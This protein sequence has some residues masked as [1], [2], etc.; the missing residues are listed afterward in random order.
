MTLT[1][2]TRDD[3][4]VQDVFAVREHLVPRETTRTA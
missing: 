4:K 2:L 1:T 3:A